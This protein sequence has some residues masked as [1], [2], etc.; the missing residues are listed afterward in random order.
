MEPDYFIDCLEHSDLRYFS[1]WIFVGEEA[2][3]IRYPAKYDSL[4]VI[5]IRLAPRNMNTGRVFTE[6]FVLGPIFSWLL[7]LKSGLDEV[8]EQATGIGAVGRRFAT[9]WWPVFQPSLRLWLHRTLHICAIG[10]AIGAIAGIYIR[11]LF[12]D[13]NVIWRSTFIKDHVIVTEALRYFLAPASILL[14]LPDTTELFSDK[15][16]SA[17]SWIHMYAINALLLIFIPRSFLALISTKA[18]S[19]PQAHCTT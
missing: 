3:F 6:R 4:S 11:G 19:S 17:E 16:V 12:L 18:L 2:R 1:A 13:Y 7:G 10:I 8:R 9:L 14:S 5:N 15:G